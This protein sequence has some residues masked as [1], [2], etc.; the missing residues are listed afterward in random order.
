M[1]GPTFA[2]FA[3]ALLRGARVHFFAYPAG[4]ALTGAALVG[5]ATAPK[6]LL[7]ASCCALG[8]AVGQLANDVFD[9]ETDRIAAPDR[10]AVQGLL[11]R[12]PT[13]VVAGVLGLVIAFVVSRLHPQAFWLAIAAAPALAIYNVTKR[14]AAGGNLSHGLLIAV[15]TLIGSAAV[16]SD[17]LGV[18]LASPAASKAALFAGLNSALYLQS[19]YEKDLEADRAAGYHTLA[20]VCGV[21]PSALLRLVALAALVVWS[22]PLFDSPLAMGFAGVG[23]ALIGLSTLPGLFTGK[24]GA[25]LRAYPL[26]VLGGVALVI[27]P[28]ATDLG[29]GATLGFFVSASALLGLA[30]RNTRNP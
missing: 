4:A 27:A 5:D 30:L 6:A 26:A 18:L 24:Q 1:S 7:A 10:P 13:L 16:S 8:W 12:K 22:R 19:N 29:V 3:A 15:A 14:F 11:P 21:R 25:S 23:A 28:A 9:V 20:V 2:S 17:S